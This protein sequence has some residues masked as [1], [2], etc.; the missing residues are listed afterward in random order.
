MERREG[1]LG[2]WR[3]PAAAAAAAFLCYGGLGIADLGFYHDDWSLLAP[4]HFAP[5]GYWAQ[6]KALSD[7]NQAM[8][9]RPLYPPF[10]TACYALFGFRPLPW[11]IASACINAL[12]AGA[13]FNV[14]AR[15]GAPRW[16][17]LLGGLWF[18]AYPSKDSTL[19]WPCIA[20]VPA[21]LL[22]FLCATLAHL[23]YVE[24][25]RKGWAAAA[26]AGLLA[27]W[28]LYDQTLFLLPLW[29]LAPG[30]GFRP[31]ARAWGG[32][33]AGL[34]AE[35][36]F[37]GYKFIVVPRLFGL[38]YNKPM[39]LTAGNF[40]RVYAGGFA[41][42]LGP[43]L[44]T[45]T[46]R[47]ALDRVREAWLLGPL[48][49]LL[50]W[51]CLRG[52]RDDA[53]DARAA[54][55]LLLWGGGLFALGYLPIAVSDYVLLPLNHMNRIHLVPALGVVAA[56]VGGLLLL[57]RRTLSRA[58]ACAL[59]GLC[60][61]A[62]GAFSTAWAESWSRQ[63]DVRRLVLRI[64]P[65]WPK[66]KLLLLWQPEFYVRR[67]APL[68][69]ASW[70]ISGAVKI[71]S[72]DPAR[73]ADILHPRVQMLPNGVFNAGEL[74][75]YKDLVILDVRRERLLSLRKPDNRAKE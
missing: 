33:A 8:Q 58:A 42:N 68:F 74:T 52:L 20:V 28:G 19:Y 35:I 1:P 39:I 23:R 44:W 69:I 25:G 71:W 16:A 60:L 41:A 57:G 59:A 11:Q 47:A 66:H 43:E 61:A 55:R 63:M 15:L 2:S 7:G 14:L 48:A 46:A 21:S 36:L 12:L 22:L 51:L 26:T 32:F 45:Y 75:P 40:L 67:K 64:L 27:S 56:A 73:R 5:E 65:D 30:E 37:L 4:L 29:L 54:K 13:V 62:H 49:C 31:P 3:V 24:T 9:F 70:D 6:L 38:A 10:F 50:P 34:C 17:A 53:P 72:D 18:L